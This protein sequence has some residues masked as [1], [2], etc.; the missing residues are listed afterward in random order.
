ME[1]KLHK[2]TIS[3]ETTKGDFFLN[4]RRMLFSKPGWSLNTN[5]TISKEL[6]GKKTLEN[7]IFT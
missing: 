3:L 7:V 6:N 1:W 5:N 4:L 2:L